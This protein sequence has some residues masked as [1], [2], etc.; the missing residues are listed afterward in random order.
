MGLE[1]L[2]GNNDDIDLSI[3]RIKEN[4]RNYKYIHNLEKQVIYN[5][6]NYHDIENK[7]NKQKYNNVKSNK[8]NSIKNIHNFNNFE[9]HEQIKDILRI[10][11]PFFE[12]NI[13]KTFSALTLLTGNGPYHEGLML[14]TNNKN[15]YI[16][17]TYPITFIKV[18]DFYKGINEIISFNALNYESKHYNISEIYSPQEPIL[19]RDI[20]KIIND[21]PNNYNLLN[22]N[23]QN[24]C[25]NI[26]KV[27]NQKFNVIIDDKPNLTKINI[28]AKQKEMKGYKTPYYRILSNNRK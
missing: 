28:L 22:N 5:V 8:N 25:N 20:L 18:Y 4:K 16:V 24:F 12:N 21:L 23:C 7:N 14:F 15:F 2:N 26:L 19:I 1:C 17:Q 6:K 13:L 11:I 10:R 3:K 9:L 27:L